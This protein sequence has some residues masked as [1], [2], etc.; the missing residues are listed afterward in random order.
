MAGA[1]AGAL[2]LRCRGPGGAQATLGGV[3]PAGDLGEFLER[4]GGAVGVPAGEQRLLSGFPPRP[5]PVPEGSLA[6]LTVAALGLASGDTVVVARREG[7]AGAAARQ[8]GDTGTSAAMVRRVVPDDNSCLF[9]AVAYVMGETRREIRGGDSA[10]LREAVVAVFRADPARYSEVMLGRPVNE[11]C[12]WIREK[13][14]WGGALELQA[15]SKHF[16]RRIY[17]FDIQTLRVDRYGEEEDYAEAAFVV[18]DGIHYDAL[19]RAFSESSPVERDVTRFEVGSPAFAAAQAAAVDLVHRFHRERAF[20]DT[21]GFTLR[22]GTCGEGVRG[23]AG[24]HAHAQRT[25]HTNFRE[26]K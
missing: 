16:R 20:T 7:G 18:Y 2:R 4:V 24:A 5:L 3:D 23:E 15:L 25:G 14:S 12:A 8:Q 21:A 13:G 26:Y 11:Y 17:A 10:G 19:A 22:C 6:G 9:N 1:P